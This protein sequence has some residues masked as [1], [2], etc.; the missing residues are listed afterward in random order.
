MSTW[1]QQAP[2]H[3]LLPALTRWFEGPIGRQLLKEERLLLQDSL[4]G[5]FGHSL[6]EL[7]LVT[8]TLT[9]RP[10]G[11]HRHYCVGPAVQR[12]L[13]RSLDAVSNFA[14]LPIANES[15][16]A[17]VLHHLLEFVANPHNMLREIERITVPRGRVLI[18]GF[19][20]FSLLGLQ[21]QVSGRLNRDS[22][23]QQ[24]MFTTFRLIDWLHLLGFEINHCWY[25]FH[26]LPLAKPDWCM[27]HSYLRPDLM[28]KLPVGGS[29]VL[30]ATKCRAPITPIKLKWRPESIVNVR[31]L[32]AAREAHLNSTQSE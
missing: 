6:L 5:V 9:S 32:G 26:R 14:Q 7:S 12:D 24:H 29:F 21:L 19:N 11:I 4:K 18:V 23:W 25:G 10:E 2:D 1:R 30:S 13:G 27:S 8:P 28:K 22:V 16:D 17:V 31:P 15:Q 20:P 3:D